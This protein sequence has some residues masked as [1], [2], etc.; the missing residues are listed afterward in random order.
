MGNSFDDDHHVTEG[1]SSIHILDTTDDPE[2]PEME[3]E[4]WRSVVW[5]SLSLRWIIQQELHR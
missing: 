2:I 1:R 4:R 3:R 5:F